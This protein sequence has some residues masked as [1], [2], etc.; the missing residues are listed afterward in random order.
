[1]ASATRI[2]LKKSIDPYKPATAS[3]NSTATKPATVAANEAPKVIPTTI[4]I[5]PPMQAT[6]AADPIPTLVVQKPDVVVVPTKA[7]D[8]AATTATKAPEVKKPEAA[9]QA[10]FK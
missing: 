7:A 2:G 4:S 1:M 8:A 9:A 5:P 3:A 6:P 10:H